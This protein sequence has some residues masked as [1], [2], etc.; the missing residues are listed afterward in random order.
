MTPLTAPKHLDVCGLPVHFV[1]QGPADAPP[2]L[3]LH[4]A[5]LSAAQWRPL[6]EALRHRLR[7]IAPDLSG[8][9][10]N[11]PWTPGEGAEALD[12]A[13]TQ[14]FREHIGQ[15][16]HLIGHSYGG[17]IALKSA[18]LHPDG[19]RTLT[20]FDPVAFG[21]LTAPDLASQPAHD[22]FAAIDHDGLFF[23]DALGG[24]EPW[25]ERFI[26]YWSG[27]GAWQRLPASQRSR[28]MRTGRKS[29]E[30]VRDISRDTSPLSAYQH[31]ACPT[32]VLTGTE[33]PPEAHAVVEALS[34]TLPSATLRYVEGGHMAPLLNPQPMIDAIT[35]LTA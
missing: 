21:V 20:L 27:Q 32:L 34:R 11:P 25:L 18:R 2:A 16:I 28:F 22:A 19:L 8:Y 14:A 5:G 12:L 33:S 29:F 10:D 15:P 4:S 30:A 31:I 35:A 13:I 6:F 3:L 9:G 1:E 24:T 26:D 23:D 7:L 17:W